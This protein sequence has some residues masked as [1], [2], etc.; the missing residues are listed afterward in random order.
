MTNRGDGATPDL[1]VVVVSYNVAPYLAR[2]LASLPA[3]CGALTREIVV[4]DNDS[5]DGS[6]DLVATCFPE[7]RLIAN[8]DNAGFARA[9]NQVLPETRGRYVLLFNPDA[10]A[11]PCALARL[12]EIADRHADVG[13]ASPLLHDPET[14]EVEL[15][16]RPFIT[17]RGAFAQ[18]TPAKWLL[19]L[20]P[21]PV[22]R[23]EI[24][25]PTTTGWLVGACLLIRRELLAALGGLD[26]AYF[27]WFEDAD[28]AARAVGAGWRLLCVSTVTVDHYGG[29][30]IEQ[31][32]AGAMQIRLFEGLLRYLSRASPRGS[33]A[34]RL[35][36]VTLLLAGAV[37][38]LPI[39]LFKAV[40]YRALGR[41]ERAARYRLRLARLLDFLWLLAARRFRRRALLSP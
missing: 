11:R 2:C 5:R 6:A 14:G 12:V 9:V 17:W 15:P 41:P 13:L 37:A 1:S 16:L 10:V 40:G 7:V 28:Y 39:L 22:W 8:R 38:R 32:R 30:S 20:S 19:R 25:R 35:L 24:D 3:G 34:L 21:H 26:G 33:A 23:P 31:E 18:Y 4:V 29:K 36:F 27:M